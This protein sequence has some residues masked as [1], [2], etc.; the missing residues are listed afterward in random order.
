MNYKVVIIE[1]EIPAAKRLALMVKSHFKEMEVIK[2]I[3]SLESAESFLDD[4]PE[5]DLFFM[6]VQLGDG[7]IFQLFETRSINKPII[8][9]TAYDQYTLKTFNYLTVDYLLKPIHLDDLKKAIKKFLQYFGRTDESPRSEGTAAPVESLRHL[10]K[11]GNQYKVI[12][13]SEVA[14][15]YIENKIVYLT[16]FT[17]KK[18]YLDRTLEEVENEF[19]GP[20][21]F[22]VNRHFIVNFHA[23][24]NLK[25]ASKS[26]LKITVEP[27]YH[28]ELFSSTSRSG[29]FKKWLKGKN[30]AL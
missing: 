12:P 9:V 17:G 22:R 21:F 14:Y 13:Y 26:R 27:P 19:C 4:S 24:K 28:N 18:F 6:D 5:V 11:S 2:I 23:I 15:Y 8:F 30:R 16:T 20:D 10:L 25:G 7:N 3:D 1:D 29:E